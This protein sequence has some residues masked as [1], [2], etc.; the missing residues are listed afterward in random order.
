MIRI[1]ITGASGFLG[2]N[3]QLRLS[4]MA[5]LSVRCFTRENRIDELPEM[6]E[7]ID[8]VFHLAG[9]NRP[10]DSSDFH[11]GN[12]VFTSFLTEALAKQV[13]KRTGNAPCLVFTSSTQA[14]L[15]NP[16]GISKRMAEEQ[17]FG[18]ASKHGISLYLY[19]LPNVFG[20][21]C[22][23]NYNSVVATFCH[24][25]TRG[26]PIAIN[27]PRTQL[28]LLHV[29]D[30]MAEFQRIVLGKRP[31]PPVGEFAS[32][33]PVY[34]ITVGD[35]A[36][37]LNRFHQSRYDLMTER[38]GQGLTRALYATYLSYLPVKSFAYSVPQHIDER[39][40]FVEMLK[41][42]DSGQFSFF[43]AHPGVTRGGHY[44]HSKTEK[45][46]VIKGDALFRF[47]QIQT[48]EYFD[49]K[50]S[51]K[52]SEIVETVPGWTHDITNIGDD[53]MIVMLW[54]NEIFDPGH[55]D[56]IKYPIGLIDRE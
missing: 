5:D 39:G 27:N 45:F 1:L 11:R 46:L 54:A 53:E 33:D 48:G 14:G 41:T 15:D 6:L 18:L 50:V 43:T 13:D 51:G 29:D 34:P 31:A 4:E 26:M 49:L 56:T 23:P 47:K 36:D 38:V 30:L 17:L 8:V 52:N 44:H 32:V 20:K 40:R 22:R 2:K 42:Q 9:I 19:R 10:D 3:L 16:Y 28:E 37:Q 35:L 21:W 55:P 7:D 25:L 12:F 24:N